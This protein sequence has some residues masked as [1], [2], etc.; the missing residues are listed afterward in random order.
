MGRKSARRLPR[1]SREH[2]LNA[3]NAGSDAVVSLVEYL[4]GQFQAA[5]DEL[6]NAL[7]E[8]SETNEKLISKV[9]TRCFLVVSSLQ[10]QPAQHDKR[11]RRA[12]YLRRSLPRLLT[13]TAIAIMRPIT[14][15]W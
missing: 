4:Q 6:S 9:Q 7:A 13:M 12:A 11:L 8:L 5:L 10:S 3:Y 2:I 15:S 1:I 14:T